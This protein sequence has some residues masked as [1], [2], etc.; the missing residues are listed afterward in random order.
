MLSTRENLVPLSIEIGSTKQQYTLEPRLKGA[1]NMPKE[2]QST[3]YE[4]RSLAMQFQ[5]GVLAAGIYLD[6]RNSN[7]SPATWDPST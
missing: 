4:I 6:D 2:K 3:N 1:P 5:T 7:N